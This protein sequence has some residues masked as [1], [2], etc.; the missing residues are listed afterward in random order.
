MGYV[1]ESRLSIILYDKEIFNPVQKEKKPIAV[2][3]LFCVTLQIVNCI[4]AMTSLFR[5]KNHTP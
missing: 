3:G 1:C 4:E 5:Q 2:G